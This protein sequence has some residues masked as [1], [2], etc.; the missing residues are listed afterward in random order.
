MHVF[1]YE[2]ITGGG[3][4]EQ[5]GALPASLLAEGSAMI[6]ALAADFTA[7]EDCQVTVLRDIR[8]DDLVFSG[9]DVIDV[10]SMPHHEDEM[11]RLAATADHTLVVAPEFDNVLLKTLALTRQ[12]GGK[13]LAPYGGVCSAR[14]RQALNGTPLCRGRNADTPSRCATS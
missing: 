4:I 6:T 10:H 7:I 3:L 5:T 13:L 9:C 14:I 2:W 8:L 11:S 12:A 1:L